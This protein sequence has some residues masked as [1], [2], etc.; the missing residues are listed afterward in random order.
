M[1]CLG[2]LCWIPVAHKS[3]CLFEAHGSGLQNLLAACSPRAQLQADVP[4]SV[5]FVQLGLGLSYTRSAGPQ[6]A[7]NALPGHRAP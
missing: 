6:V 3:K 7:Q 5:V 4:P 1:W 2:H